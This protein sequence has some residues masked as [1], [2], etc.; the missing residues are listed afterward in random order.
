MIISRN[1]ETVGAFD[2][3]LPANTFIL[4]S[5]SEYRAKV[6]AKVFTDLGRLVETVSIYSDPV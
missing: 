5:D 4:D 2:K 6:T 1:C 3:E